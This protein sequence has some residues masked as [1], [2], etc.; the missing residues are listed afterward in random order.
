MRQKRVYLVDDDPGIR[1]SLTWLMGAAGIQLICFTGAESFLKQADSTLPGCVLLDICMPGMTGVELQEHLQC[2]ENML[3]II[4]LTGHADVPTTTHIF[5]NGAFDLMEKPVDTEELLRGIH[6]ALESSEKKYEWHA[7]RR[8]L[9]EAWEELTDREK[10]ILLLV[11]EGLSNKVIAD[12]LHLALR[13]V[14]IHRHNMMKKMGTDSAIQLAHSV[15]K[16]MDIKEFKAAS[17]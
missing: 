4:F 12:R 3:S 5:K 6:L 13:T 10:Q 9:T 15:S 7:G 1:E 2:K 11:L 17:H 16:Y 8:R 14:E